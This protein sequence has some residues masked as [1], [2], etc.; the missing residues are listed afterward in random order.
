[1]IAKIWESTK[2]IEIFRAVKNEDLVS[3]GGSLSASKRVAFLSVE[4]IEALN[5]LESSFITRRVTRKLLIRGTV[6]KNS[7]ALRKLHPIS[8]MLL[9]SILPRN[10]AAA[11]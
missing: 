11:L 8:L 10:C 9:H 6:D 7:A 5:S 4:V 2:H 3:L 1:M